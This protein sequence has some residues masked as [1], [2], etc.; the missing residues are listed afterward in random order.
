MI[1]VFLGFATDP[2]PTIRMTGVGLATA[3]LVDITLVRLLLAPASLALLGD[4]LWPS[5]RLQHPAV[6]HELSPGRAG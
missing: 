3:I 6:D 5:R 1:V 2:D 4:R